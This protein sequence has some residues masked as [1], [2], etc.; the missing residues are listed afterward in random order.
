[1]FYLI[2][3]IISSAMVSI[4]MRISEKYTKGNVSL[5]A[6]NYMM[7]LAIAGGY[8]GAA[9]WLPK[10]DGI[11]IVT[12]LGIINGLLYLLGFV[13]LQKNVKENGVVLSA[14]FIKLGL[15]VPMVLSITVFG[16]RPKFVQMIGFAIAVGAIVLNHF[17]KETTAM[18]SRAGLIFLLLAG[19]SGDAMSK[20]FEEIGNTQFS[21]QFLLY[22]FASALILCIGLVILRKEKIGKKEI[23]FGFL[24]GIPNYF[25]ARFLLRA[26]EEMKAVIVYPTYSVATIV[27]VTLTGVFFFK[28]HLGKRQKMAIGL[29]LLALALLNL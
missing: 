14:T 1:M 2:L 28:E 25:S 10:G 15:L 12:G 7:C 3:A 11:G 19:G 5:L 29:I 17:E 16:E 13:L 18:K 6:A 4:T 9:G 23:G 8:T 21:E 20:V 24:I 22:T 26:L 27:V